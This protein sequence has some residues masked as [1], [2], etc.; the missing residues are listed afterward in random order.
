MKRAL[1]KMPVGNPLT[2]AATRSGGKTAVICPDAGAR[3]TFAEIDARANRL[4]NGLAGLGLGEGDVLAFLVSNRAGIVELYFAFS[5]AGIVGAPLNRRLAPSGL[6]GPME[7]MGAS[8]LVCEDRVAAA[9]CRS[10][11]GLRIRIGAPD[12]DGADGD[13]GRG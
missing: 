2:T 6:D 11:R 10:G 1:G 3:T 9:A 13:E 4:A 7:T 8:A 12:G 5:R